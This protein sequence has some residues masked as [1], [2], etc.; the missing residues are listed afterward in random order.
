M[1]TA[2]SL[3]KSALRKIGVTAKGGFDLDTYEQSDAFDELKG[4]DMPI[5]HIQVEERF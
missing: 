2:Q 1:A 4:R 3:I 5:A